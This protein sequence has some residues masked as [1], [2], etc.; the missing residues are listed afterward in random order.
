MYNK[1]WHKIEKIRSTWIKI[2]G[3]FFSRRSM[4]IS[5]NYK[6]EYMDLRDAEHF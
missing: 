2:F 4:D 6:L 3:F 1:E 5:S